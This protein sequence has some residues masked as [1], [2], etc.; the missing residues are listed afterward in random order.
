MLQPLNE[1]S[2][3]GKQKKEDVLTEAE[4]SLAQDGQSLVTEVAKGVKRIIT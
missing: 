1:E 2:F 4:K 3:L